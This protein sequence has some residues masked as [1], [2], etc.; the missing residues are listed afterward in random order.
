MPTYAVNVDLPCR[1]CRA[2]IVAFWFKLQIYKNYFV[3]PL[4]A[5]EFKL[6]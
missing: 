6:F 1:Y 5:N 3:L 4:N 2:V